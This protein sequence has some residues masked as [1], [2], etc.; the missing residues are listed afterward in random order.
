MKRYVTSFIKDNSSK[1]TIASDGNDTENSSF[2][3]INNELE[4]E[5]KIQF[6]D[7][8]NVEV[9]VQVKLSETQIANQNIAALDAGGEKRCCLPQILN[10]VLDQISLP[11]IYAAFDELQIDLYTCTPEQLDIFKKAKIIPNT[12]NSCDLILKSDAERLCSR[13]LERTEVVGATG[14]ARVASVVSGNGNKADKAQDILAGA[15]LLE[16][17]LL[18]TQLANCKITR[19][20]AAFDVGGE[21]WCC[22]PQILN[23]VLNQI[24]LPAIHA[25]CDELQIYCSTCTPEQLDV[26]KK[27]KIVSN[28]ANSCGL[29]TKSDAE[30]LCSRLLKRTEV[31][32]AT[33]PAR[34]A[35]VKPGNRNK[36]DK[37]QIVSA[38]ANLKNY[39]D[40]QY[41]DEFLDECD[42]SFDQQNQAGVS[43]LNI[44]DL[45]T[46]NNLIHP[47]SSK[48]FQNITTGDAGVA[49]GQ[50]DHETNNRQSQIVSAGALLVE[51]LKTTNK[52][53]HPIC[54]GVQPNWFYQKVTTGGA[55]VAQGR[56]N[57]ETNNRQNLDTILEA[58][59]CLESDLQVSKDSQ[60]VI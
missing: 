27:A 42:L 35:S 10:S 20:I 44:E 13:L 32:V 24:T 8:N 3:V 53:I 22:L 60:K 41:I 9:T 48:L 47:A 34:V 33:G 1:V 29:I 50:L 11:S 28:T 25:A 14:P 23:G 21:K 49:Q 4:K 51:E 55:G 56:L 5:V 39:L 38:G 26:F 18:E 31:V 58:V 52:V 30:R 45:K 37:A 59:K 36:A 57:H 2:V 54:P 40:S 17:N 46:R 19:N 12:A 16:A 6:S 15:L 43:E 7:E